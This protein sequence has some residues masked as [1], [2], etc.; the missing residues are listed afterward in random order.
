MC[1]R[2]RWSGVEWS[3]EWSVEW[4]NSLARLL[5]VEDLAGASVAAVVVSA[6]VTVA[7]GLLGISAVPE[8]TQ[9]VYS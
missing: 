4:S 7:A 6:R 9:P 8:A 5:A 1:V 2:E 3:Y